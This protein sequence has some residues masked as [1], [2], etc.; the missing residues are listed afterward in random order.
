MRPELENAICDQFPKLYGRT[1]HSSHRVPHLRLAIEDGWEPLLRELS[2]FLESLII[3]KSLPHHAI[4]VKEKYGELRFYTDPAPTAEMR[5]LISGATRASRAVCESC[6][7][8]GHAYLILGQGIKARCGP[9]A[10]QLN[11]TTHLTKH[12]KR[13]ITALSRVVLDEET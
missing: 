7:G 12:P 9:C 11:G 3:Q 6:G 10:R 4:V 5:L 1:P 13:R 2:H 8:P